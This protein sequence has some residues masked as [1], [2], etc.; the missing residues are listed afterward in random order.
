[1][2]YVNVILEK[3]RTCLELLPTPN[4]AWAVL[5]WQPYRKG[6]RSITCECGGS[7][8]C[9]CGT[10]L[11]SRAG[12]VTRRVVSVFWKNWTDAACLRDRWELGTESNRAHG[13]L[14]EPTQSA[15]RGTA[16]RLAV[17]RQRISQLFLGVCFIFCL[18]SGFVVISGLS[19][20]VVQYETKESRNW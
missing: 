19:C 17:R 4:A 2:P 11:S 15:Q 13:V 10:W 6:T 18:V 14:G 3:F 8:G 5:L 12:A 7:R 1:M 20:N 16:E 9:D